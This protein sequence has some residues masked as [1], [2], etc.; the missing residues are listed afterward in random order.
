MESSSDLATAYNT[1]NISNNWYFCI[2]GIGYKGRK[3]TIEFQ[4]DTILL[5][6]IDNMNLGWN[7]NTISILKFEIFMTALNEKSNDL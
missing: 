4:L 1:F 2:A 5:P 3:R 6:S 7:D